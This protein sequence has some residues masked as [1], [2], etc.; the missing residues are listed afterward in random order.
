MRLFVLFA[1]VALA[2]LGAG[3]S[4]GL[5]DAA[6]SNEEAAQESGREVLAV[7]PARPLPSSPLSTVRGIVMG[8]EKDLARFTMHLP[9]DS[10]LLIQMEHNSLLRLAGN[11]IDIG[12]LRL[13]DKVT[14]AYRAEE[15]RN[16]AQA[17]TV[18]R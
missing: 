6:R 3:F 4:R 17:I 15:G 12:D 9:D 7:M 2:V 10:A 18:D 14:V 13:G 8:I 16:I 1:P 5:A 11:E